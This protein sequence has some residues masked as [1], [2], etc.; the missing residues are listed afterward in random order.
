M[1][2]TLVVVAMALSSVLSFTEHAWRCPLWKESRSK[3]ILCVSICVGI[4]CVSI[5]E[6]DSPRRYLSKSMCSRD[7]L[8]VRALDS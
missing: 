2:M 8:L 5:C 7:I 4:F 1:M 3:C 6:L